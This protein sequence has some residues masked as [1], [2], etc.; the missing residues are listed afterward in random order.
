MMNTAARNIHVQV[1]AQVQT[2]IFNSLGIE[3]LGHTE[4]LSLICWGATRLFSKV[5]TSFY[6]PSEVSE[7]SS[8]LPFLLILVH[9]HL[10]P[11]KTSSWMWVVC[12]AVVLIFIFLMTKNV[13]KS[14]YILID[15]LYIFS[16]VNVYSDWMPIINW[17][18]FI[19]EFMCSLYIL[20]TKSFS[21]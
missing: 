13:K 5:S 15:H 17:V 10:L 12:L 9:I 16:G 20:D 3:S 1:H 21:R 4:A 7:D 6:I 14:F 18:I 2:H 11:L 8:F 19:I